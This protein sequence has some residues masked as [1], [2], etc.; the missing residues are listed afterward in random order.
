M[1]VNSLNMASAIMLGAGLVLASPLTAFAA[2]SATT[3]PMMG[4]AASGGDSANTTTAPAGKLREHDGMLRASTLVGANVYNDQGK[5]V[6]T[7]HDLLVSPTGSVQKAVLSVGGFLGVGTHYVAVSI[8]QMKIEPTKVNA[9]MNRGAT[10]TTAMGGTGATPGATPMSA[11]GVMN[12]PGAMHGA[13]GGQYYSVVLP[14]A[15]KASLK[16]MPEF[17]FNS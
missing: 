12:Q 1:R 9:T 8:A 14:G 16:S 2:N 13:S 6:G 3:S 17:K 10:G 11:A 4:T 7:V 5:V 15:T